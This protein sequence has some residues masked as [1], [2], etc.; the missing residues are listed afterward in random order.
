MLYRQGFTLIEML[1]VLII[2][3]V[4]IALSFP[5]FTAPT[6]QARALN[7]QNNLL[8]IYTAQRNYLNNN[9]SFINLAPSNPSDTD[10]VQIIDSTLSLN[11]QDDGS[12]A[13]SCSGNTC[14]ASR[15][16]SPSS[17]LIKLSLNL[18]IQ[19]SGEIN[20]KCTSSTG[21]TAWC[22]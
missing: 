12:Y 14:Q 18:P 22:P 19:L 9:G 3:A 1:V 7:A 16:G 11:I 17:L 21:K 8:A 4:V 6:E 2:I 13:Y 20:P 15:N 5:N 10:G